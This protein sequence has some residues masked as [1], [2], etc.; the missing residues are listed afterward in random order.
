MK[1]KLLI[2]MGC[3]FTEGV[4]CYDPKTIP[5]DMVDRMKHEKIE[6]VYIS[7]KGR[8]HEYSWPSFLQ[9]KLKYD[10]LINLG[11]GGSSTS[12]NVKVWFEKYH[13]KNFS[14]NYEVLII[15]LLPEP[16]RFSFYKKGVVKNINP[17]MSY[18]VY[19]N[20]CYNLGIEYVKFIQDVSIDPFL[21]QIFYIKLME[22]HCK[23]KKYNLLYSPLDFN[24]NK[25][26]DKLHNNEFR[27]VF[28]KNIIPD[29]SSFPSM[30]SPICNHPNEKGYEYISEIFFEWIKINK[31][32]LLNNEDPD[33]YDSIW[34]GYPIFDHLHG[35]KTL[36]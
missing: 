33:N 27:M 15:W 2:T 22:E 1:K 9:K 32:Y 24:Q 16:S 35:N 14:D 36:I 21:E 31:S 18:N 11:F 12:G 34:D 28:E 8:F 29:F 4:G 17:A 19:N 25:L 30:K 23:F 3:S 13:N 10:K 26:F 20:D 7:N 5:S 6:E